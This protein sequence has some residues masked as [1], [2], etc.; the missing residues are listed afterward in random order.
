MSRWP[1]HRLAIKLP[2]HSSKRLPFA[3]PPLYQ[4]RYALEGGK[5]D[6]SSISERS[7]E[8]SAASTCFDVARQAIS[9]AAIAPA[10]EPAKRLATIPRSS[11]ACAT[12]M[13][14]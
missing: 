4:S 3:Q 7:N 10:E 9:P 5:Y 12:P 2:Y 8:L 13:Y 14:A 11:R 6:V 1:S